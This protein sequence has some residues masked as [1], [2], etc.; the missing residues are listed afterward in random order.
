MSVYRDISTVRLCLSDAQGSEANDL[1]SACTAHSSR[2]T[3]S[4]KRTLPREPRSRAEREIELPK[5]VKSKSTDKTAPTQTSRSQV[6][7]TS[8]FAYSGRDQERQTW[9]G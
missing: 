3:A 9:L 6:P 8:D 2:R 7:E 1:R 4:P 5:R